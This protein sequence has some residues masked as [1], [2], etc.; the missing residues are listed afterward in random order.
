[1]RTPNMSSLPSAAQRVAASMPTNRSRTR[2]HTIRHQFWTL[3]FEVQACLKAGHYAKKLSEI[4]GIYLEAELLALA[5]LAQ[6]P[7]CSIRTTSIPDNIV[8]DVACEL[9][10]AIPSFAETCG[11]KR[12]NEQIQKDKAKKSAHPLRNLGRPAANEGS[13]LRGRSPS[14]ARSSLHR[15][16]MQSHAPGLPPTR[17]CPG[18]LCTLHPRRSRRSRTS[19]SP[20]EAHNRLVKG[21]G[22]IERV[23]SRSMGL[24]CSRTQDMRA[25]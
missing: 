24:L 17:A 4:C 20:A 11:S 25:K 14:R 5:K 21:V 22:A 12:C 19:A 2:L 1:M 23:P 13:L 16:S 3:L 8:R 6:T 9:R 18:H 10:C 15:R 7:R